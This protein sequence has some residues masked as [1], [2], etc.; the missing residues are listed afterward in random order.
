MQQPLKLSIPIACVTFLFSACLHDDA[1]NSQ[2]ML[3]SSQGDLSSIQY[4]SSNQSSHTDISS[5]QYSINY[6]TSSVIEYSSQIDESSSQLKDFFSS[7]VI[8]SSSSHNQPVS[9]SSVH[10]SSSSIDPYAIETGVFTD[11]RDGHEYRWTKIN[12][13][14]WMGGNLNFATDE[15]S[16]CFNDSLHNCEIF[17]RLYTWRT[18]MLGA[19]ES[20]TIPS[21]VQGV[22]P[23]NWHLPSEAE[24]VLLVSFVSDIPRGGE[25]LKTTDLWIRFPGT[26]EFKFYANPAGHRFP[27]G[28]FYGENSAASWWSTE[29]EGHNERA[30][31]YGLSSHDNSFSWGPIE[32]D[33]MYSVRCLKDE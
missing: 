25:L 24:W 32:Q 8:E 21:G 1:T 22:C 27:N 13:Q 7:S 18:A 10:M 29:E 14:T 31:I 20:K 30:V 6:L 2:S 17:G 16:T 15:G 23:N 28:E 9:S 4:V 33:M 11:E 19:L 12:G 26:N 3:S 5:I